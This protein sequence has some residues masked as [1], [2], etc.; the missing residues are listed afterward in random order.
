MTVSKLKS[1]L[2]FGGAAIVA[3]AVILGFKGAN[4]ANTYGASELVSCQSH[5]CTLKQFPKLYD[6]ID[7]APVRVP[8]GALLTSEEYMDFVRGTNPFKYLSSIKYRGKDYYFIGILKPNG[9]DYMIYALTS[10]NKDPKY[11]STEAEEDAQQAFE[12]SKKA[13]KGD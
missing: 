6:H 7:M 9:R 1:Y 13:K 3:I 12:E 2:G 11:T 4:N 5:T 8:G 10:Q